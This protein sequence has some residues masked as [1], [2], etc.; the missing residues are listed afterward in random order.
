MALGALAQPA[1]QLDASLPRQP[2]TPTTK[3]TVLNAR[4]GSRLSHSLVTSEKGFHTGTM[5]YD[6]DLHRELLIEIETPKGK[7][8]FTT[9]SAPTGVQALANQ[10]IGLGMTAMQLTGESPSEYKVTATLVSPFTPTDSLGDSTG[11]RLSITPAYYWQISVTNLAGSPL[12]GT[13]KLGLK[14]IPYDTDKEVA[15]SWWRRNKPA[16]TLLFKD[17]AGAGSFTALSGQQK[18]LRHFD[19]EAFNGLAYDFEAGKGVT[20]TENLVFAGYHP[21]KV[22]T[23]LKHH[24]ELTFYYTRFYK[25][26]E[27]VLAWAHQNQGAALAASQK[28][29]KV[30]SESKATPEEKWV[31]ALSF[32]TD[33]ANTFLLKVPAGQARFYLTEGRFRHMN[34]IDVAHETEV[35]AVF[36]PWRLKLQLEQ[37]TDYLATKEVIVP[38]AKYQGRQLYNLEGVSATELGPY[39]YHDV[40]NFPYVMPAE[41]YDFGPMMPIEENSTF[42]LLLYWYWKLT[43]DDAFARRHIG[44]TQVLLQSMMNR[45]SDGNGLADYGMGWSTYDVSEAIK[46]SPEN[47]YLGVKQLAAYVAGAEMLTGLAQKST[48][49]K[50]THLAEKGEDGNSLNGNQ[51]AQ[52]EK[53]LIDNTWLRKRQ[54]EQCLAEARKILGSLQAARQHHGFL[55]VSLDTTFKGWNQHSIVL[56]EG[57]F[58]PALS[59]LNHPIIMETASLLGKTYDDAMTRSRTPYGIKLSSNEPVTWFS[60]IMVSDVVASYYFNKNNSS[61]P[62]TYKWNRDNLMAYQDG[63]FDEKTPWPGNWYPRGISSLGYILRARQFKASQHSAFA[64][65]LK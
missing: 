24:Q 4:L 1:F 52:F 47:V 21:G 28:F 14:A 59:G 8:C 6:N 23:D 15:L 56:C 18:N 37:W 5:G 16:N 53:G 22:M 43:G 51:K 62:F 57:L 41:G 11:I 38:S 64:N 17:V 29:E 54:A 35:Q 19:E 48:L 34:T 42:T 50:N 2:L 32:H 60:K 26:I 31:T 61:A 65:S 3:L 27:E 25:N 36:T 63:A 30:L 46:R 49:P 10:Q 33:L 13:V 7:R 58:L 20:L 9:C 12:K 55:P 39:L 45:D 40:G 44:L